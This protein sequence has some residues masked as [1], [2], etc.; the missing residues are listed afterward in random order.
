MRRKLFDD[1]HELFRD[2]VRTFIEREVRPHI[3]E[4]ESAGIV[5]RNMYQHAGAA[6]LMAMAAP[7]NYGG[8]DI[9]DFRFNAIISEE[10]CRAGALG[11]S[12]GIICH[13]DVVLPYLLDLAD[14]QQQGRWLPGMCLGELLGAIAMTEPDTGSD[15]SAIR[16]KAVRDGDH[17]IVNGTKTFISN[18]QNSDLIIVVC[19]TGDSSTP[20]HSNLSLL[21]VESTMEGFAR[22]QNLKKAGQHSADTSELFFED[23]HVPAANLLGNEGEAFKYMVHRLPQERLSIAIAAIAHASAAFDWTLDYCR[24]RRAFGQPIG[25][26]QNS[27]F[28]LATMRTELDIAQ[29]L[30]DRHTEEHN[31]GTLSAEDA[32]EAKWWCADLN[33]RVLD[34]CLQLHGGNGYMD[35]FPISRAWRD[36]RAMSIYGGTNEIMKEIIGRRTLG[37]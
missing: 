4:W 31:E 32:A 29:I 17:Y 22:G 8:M 34:Q 16:T 11:A 28:A 18:G 21:V 6:G 15:L 26:F 20:R 7:A 14:D 9:T 13:N 5:A 30:V 25:S 37:L 24:T 19:R 35:E 1:T 36:G 12:Q 3:D 33:R 10:F 27:R 23:V 2:T